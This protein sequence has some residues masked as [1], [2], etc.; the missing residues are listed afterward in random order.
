[1]FPVFIE[2][3]QSSIIQAVSHIQEEL[4]A[5]CSLVT[6]FFTVTWDLNMSF[7]KQHRVIF[8]I[9]FPFFLFKC[10]LFIETS[11]KKDMKAYF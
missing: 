10:S 11:V 9:F 3:V 4:G 8:F 6:L 1:M 2:E 7:Q 5:M